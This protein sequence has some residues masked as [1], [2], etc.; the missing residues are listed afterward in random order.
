[1]S[2]SFDHRGKVAN[3]GHLKLTNKQIDDIVDRVW[4]Q[5]QDKGLIT[6][7]ASESEVRT[8]IAAS[9][10]GDLEIEQQIEQEA[11]RMLDN[12]ERTNAGEFQRYKMFPMLKQKLA[13]EK[14]FI[15]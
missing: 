6:L 8:R 12:L 1:M 9:L 11:N 2:S 13:K 10:I 3:R 4:R 15:L 7:K 14:K 5:W